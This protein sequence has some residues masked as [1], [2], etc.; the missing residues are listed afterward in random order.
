MTHGPPK[1]D[2]NFP[3]WKA[4]V[5]FKT[6][7]FFGPMTEADDT[8]ESAKETVKLPPDEQTEGDSSQT[9]DR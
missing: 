4:P 9:T 5:V 2:K 3:D 7:D 8:Q 1:K 6:S